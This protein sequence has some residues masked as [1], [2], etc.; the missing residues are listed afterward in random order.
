MKTLLI[1]IITLSLVFTVACKPSVKNPV[2]SDF[3]ASKTKVLIGEKVEFKDESSGDV[4]SRLWD[5]GDNVTST[6]WR[7]E[8]SYET[9]GVYTVSFKVSNADGSDIETKQDYIYVSPLS[10]DFIFCS[11][12]TKQRTSLIKKRTG[13]PER[14]LN[15][16]CGRISP[17]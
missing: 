11:N 14:W 17:V 4:E 9:A 3:S 8:H 15:D 5:F 13:N 1:T 6:Q 7:P 2:T 10:V 12:V 16:N